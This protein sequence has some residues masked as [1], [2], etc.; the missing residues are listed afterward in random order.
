MFIIALEAVSASLA[1]TPHSLMRFPNIRAPMSGVAL[2]SR[3]A[4]TMRTE[5]GKII[6]SVL[7]TGLSCCILIFL[8]ASDVRAFMMGGWMTGTSAM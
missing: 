4:Q 1:V 7:E 8:S 3:K 2:G 6:F 5:I